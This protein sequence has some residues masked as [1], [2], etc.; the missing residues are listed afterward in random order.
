MI[1]GSEIVVINFDQEL[2]QI[3]HKNSQEIKNEAWWLQWFWIVSRQLTSRYF[4]LQTSPESCARNFN[5]IQSRD[6]MPRKTKLPFLAAPD[7]ILPRCVCWRKS[8]GETDQDGP[9]EIHW[10]FA[11]RNTMMPAR[12]TDWSR[13]WPLS[14]L[15]TLLGG[16][17]SRE[18]SENIQFIQY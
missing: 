14:S 4:C 9:R 1:F 7:Q 16:L 10:N 11:S 15:L 8:E 17:C 6:W 3:N 12:L 2:Q 5:Q 18:A 13:I